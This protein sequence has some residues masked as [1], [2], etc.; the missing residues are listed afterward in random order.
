MPRRS[1]APAVVGH[2]LLVAGVGERGPDV[3]EQ[4]AEDVGRRGRAAGQRVDE[5]AGEAGAAGPPGGDAEDLGRGRRAAVA[6]PGVPRGGLDQAADQAGEGD[7]VLDVQRDVGG[8]DLDG[9][10]LLREAGV[11]IDHAGVEDRVGG[12]DVVDEPVVVGGVGERPRWGR[13]GQ[14]SQTWERKLA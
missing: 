14:R 10:P 12:Q 8:A 3:V 7:G 4:G 6:V 13:Q 1:S 9:R 5:V 11:E 2:P